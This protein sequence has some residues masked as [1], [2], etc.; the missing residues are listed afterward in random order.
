[1][2]DEQQ[3]NITNQATNQSAQEPFHAPTTIDQRQTIDDHRTQHFHINLFSAGV[4]GAGVISASVIGAFLLV[5]ALVF[6]FSA[7]TLPDIPSEDATIQE[8][9][10][11]AFEQALF[12]GGQ[13]A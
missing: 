8:P 5:S 1:M 12:E 7:K 9:T 6:F 11:N 2:S 4:I 3:L 10:R 13:P